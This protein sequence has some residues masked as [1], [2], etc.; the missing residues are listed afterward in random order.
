MKW[1]LFH[2]H[3]QSHEVLFF[4][5]LHSFTTNNHHVMKGSELTKCE[6]SS[7]NFMYT[8][9]I[10]KYNNNFKR[11]FTLNLLMLN[12]TKEH[13]LLVSISDFFE[14]HIHN[15][16]ITLRKYQEVSVLLVF[17]ASR[18]MLCVCVIFVFCFVCVRSWS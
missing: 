4:F 13:Y 9:T 5:Y 8:E 3:V 14:L 18:V 7:D 10:H 16:I 17:S 6:M 2:L 12:V 11:I 15:I 1:W